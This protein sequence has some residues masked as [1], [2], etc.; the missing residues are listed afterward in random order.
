MISTPRPPTRAI[1]AVESRE[2]KAKISCTSLDSGV[3][4]VSQHEV[5][6]LTVP[7]GEPRAL[8]AALTRVLDDRALRDRLGLAARART[9]AEFDVRVMGNRVAAMYDKVL[10]SAAVP[11]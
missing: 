5:T 3:P 8:G 11:A 9:H 6:G 7:P 1:E 4:W 10:A 2:K